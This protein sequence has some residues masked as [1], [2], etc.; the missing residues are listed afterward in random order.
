MKEL[1]GTTTGTA[2]IEGAYKGGKFRS[3]HL[4]WLRYALLAIYI[5]PLL[6]IA[7]IYMQYIYP[8][9]AASGEEMMALSVSAVLTLAVVLSVFGLAL[10]SRT[11]KASVASLHDLNNRMD[12]ILSA[13]R[14]F[15]Q[16]GYVDTLVDSVSV[17]AKNMLNAE[18]SSLLLY[19]GEG[20][21]RFEYVEGPAAR[22]LKG[23]AVKVGEGIT[24]WAAKERSAMIVNDVRKDPR[25]AKAF[26]K[27]SGFIT[28]SIL[29]VPL[30]FSG[31][32]L[33]VLE[34]INKSDGSGFTEHDKDVLTALAEHASAAIYKNKAF[35]EMKSDFV[36]VTD[37]LLMAVDDLLPQKKGHS[38]R[39]ARY[40]VKLA[41]GLG[42]G[43]DEVRDIYFGALLHD[44]GFVG[45]DVVDYSDRDKLKQHAAA[46]GDMM[47][48]IYQWR[49]VS[50]IIH[51][52]HERYDGKGYPSELA[53]EAIT[54][55]GRVIALAEALDV[56]TSKH[57]YKLPIGFEEAAEEIRA[58]AGYQFD[59]RVV[60]VFLATFDEDDVLDN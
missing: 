51:D 49:N 19:D 29:C 7:V 52:H 47:K 9:I 4:D 21:L 28:K 38:R 53:G 27:E 12:G 37:L 33:G 56:M 5:V 44:V 1:S 22:H 35:D 40:S 3:M 18:A 25:F 2:G 10:I 59:P 46:G 15:E 54:L 20:S 57:S 16:D 8:M 45:L 13:T 11:A 60:D 14:H 58:L 39:V 6:V 55:G 34:V 23:K 36:Q 41:K 30:V 24:G 43:D 26:D 42:L 31:R 32:D 48:N 50:R 17:S